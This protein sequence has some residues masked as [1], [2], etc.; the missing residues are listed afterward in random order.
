MSKRRRGMW[1]TR[2]TAVRGEGA[3]ARITWFGRELGR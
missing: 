1:T 2:V 3:T